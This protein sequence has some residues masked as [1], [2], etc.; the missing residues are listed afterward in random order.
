MLFDG[1][2]NTIEIKW[3]SVDEKSRGK[4][5]GE[6]MIKEISD[7]F[8]E[9]KIVPIDILLEAQI[10]WHKMKNKGFCEVR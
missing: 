5:L 7:F 8:P 4:G 2:D 1:L 3:F 9:K 6:N 10:F